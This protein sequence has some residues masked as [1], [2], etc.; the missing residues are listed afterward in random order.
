MDILSLFSSYFSGE[1]G[2]AGPPP[3]IGFVI[4]IPSVV[5]ILSDV[6]R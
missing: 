3:N 1:T 2:I 6:G 4:L 5:R